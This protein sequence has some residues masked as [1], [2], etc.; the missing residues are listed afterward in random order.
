VERKSGQRKLVT[1]LVGVCVLVALTL[2]TIASAKGYDIVTKV[3]HRYE[4]K[5]PADKFEEVNFKSRGQTYPVY[6]FFL[7]G[8]PAWPALIHVHGR[9]GSRH[10]DADLERADAWRRLGYNVLSIDLSDNGGDTIGDGRSTLGFDEQYDVLGAFDYLLAQGYTPD[11]IG[12][13]SISMGAASSLMAASKEPRIKAIWEDSGYSRADSVLWEQ[14]QSAGLP[15]IIVPGG[16]AWGALFGGDRIWEV[17]P[18][19]H[20]S[21]FAANKLALYITH[22]DD[23]KLVFYHHGVDMYNAFKAAGVEVTFWSLRG[24]GHGQIYDNFSQEY[25][26]RLDDFFKHHLTFLI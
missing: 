1:T 25:L 24:L 13:V 19:T 12:I 7:Q 4:P 18:I 14:A 21:T 10:N 15:P 6:A 3:P 8:D 11:R 17:A 2:Y 26:R 20:A 16:F 23:D 5:T 22:S 9:F